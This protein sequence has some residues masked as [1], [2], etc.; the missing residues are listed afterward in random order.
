M[1]IVKSL[2]AAAILAAAILLFAAAS[3]GQASAQTKLLGQACA[4]GFTAN[5][6]SQSANVQVCQSSIAVCAMRPGM[7][8]TAQPIAPLH[9]RNGFTLRYSC[10]YQPMSNTQ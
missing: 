4:P 3:Q 7:N 9:G 6:L 8:V 10:T 5:A 2:S 1:E